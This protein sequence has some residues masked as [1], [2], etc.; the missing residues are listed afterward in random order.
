MDWMRGK[1]SPQESMF[2]TVSLDKMVEARM[3]SD[4]PLRRIKAYSEDVLKSLNDDFE[5][6]YAKGGRPSIPPEQILLALLWQALFSIRSERLLED[7]MRYDLRCRWFVGLRL[8][9]EPWDHSTFSRA[10]ESL[11]LQA[12]TQMFF[13]KHVEFLRAEGLASSDHLSVDGTLLEAHASQKS[14]VLK[15]DFDDDGNPPPAGPGGRN[16]WV[17]FKGKKRSNETHRSVTDPEARLASKG[18]GAKPCHELDVVTENR[19]NLVVDFTISAPGGSAERENARALVGL[20]IARGHKPKTVGADRGYSNGDDLVLAFDNMGVTPHF[21][22]RDDR[23]NS[24]AR[25]PSGDSGYEV[26]MRKRMQIEEVFAYAK[27]IAGLAKLRVCGTLRA[28]GQAGIA[29][30][31]YNLTRHASLT[32]A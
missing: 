13:E 21:A 6:L 4:H 12:L 22:V 10:R 1:R 14:F 32:R 5:S 30:A 17:D 31:A 9:E 23:P 29:L 27:C 11:R 2:V 16:G 24:L 28:F 18:A 15:D 3:P 8:D 20:L 25:V 26:S 19:N 7:V